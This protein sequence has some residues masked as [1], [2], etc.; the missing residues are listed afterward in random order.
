MGHFAGTVAYF[1][2]GGL[3]RVAWV[4]FSPTKATLL[5]RRRFSFNQYGL[6]I[7]LNA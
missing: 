3:R 2:G 5:S 4:I 6:V 7:S 1:V